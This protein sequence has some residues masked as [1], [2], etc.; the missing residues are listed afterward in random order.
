MNVVVL[1]AGEGKR[2]HS[3]VPKVLQHLGG[4]PLLRWVLDATNQLEKSGKT[5]V[6]VGH[7]AEQVKE[8]FK[9]EDVCYAHQKEQKGTAHA[10]IQALEHLKPDESVL[11]L[12]GDVPLV[13]PET[14]K[15]LIE[16]A[17]ED[18]GVLTVDLENPEGY[19]RILREDGKVVGIVEDKDAS[20]D[21]KKIKEINTGIMVLPSA[22]LKDWLSEVECNNSQHEYYL[23]D[24]ISM[25]VRDNVPVKSVKASDRWEAEGVN[26][27]I[28]QNALERALQ[29]KL[30]E[31][32]LRQGV[33]LADKNRI[34]IRGKLECGKDVFIDVG[35]VFEG[36]VTLG[37]NVSVGPYSILKDS[38]IGNGTRIDAFC[39]IVE[40]KV[41]QDAIIGPYARLRPQAELSDNVH[42]GNFV[43]V[44]KSTIGK[45][46]KVNHLT[47]IGDC[48]MGS[49]VNI[50]AGTITCNYDGANKHQTVIGDD[51]FIGSGTQLVAPVTV[52]KGATVGA[53]TTVTKKVPDG[54]LMIRRAKDLVIPAWKRPVK[55]K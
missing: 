39:H 51:C 33:R 42:I 27:R 44:K 41:G 10:V 53:G 14:L 35:C 24:L 48:T 4:R 16:E 26:D 29:V 37:N 18:V 1:A 21:Q 11:V 40:A 50:G 34:D 15:S 32:L 38:S 9:D 49:G 45:A 23:T 8:A 19:G 52:G 5:V 47:Y 46:S 43:E 22:K 7:G 17:G 31:D 6:V 13:N 55:Q 54:T 20:D 25:A 36:N 2:M 3:N 12:Y 28:Q 30:A